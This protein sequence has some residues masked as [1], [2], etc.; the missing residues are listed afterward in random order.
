M[1]QNDGP[2]HVGA[3]GVH[4]FFIISGFVMVITSRH[5]K[6]SMPA[7]TFLW[8]RFLRIY[9]TYWLVAS[10]YLVLHL[11]IWRR[12]PLTLME[13]AASFALYSEY[14]SSIIG[15]GWTL[16]Y[17]VY[18]Y[19]CFALSLL[20]RR[21][22]VL[23]TAFFVFSVGAAPVIGWA[24]HIA[25][26]S[27]LI[28]FVAGC[29]LGCFYLRRPSMLG[30]LG[31]PSLILGIVLLFSTIILPRE[32]PSGI[33]MGLPSMLIVAGAVSMENWLQGRT[34]RYIA[35]LGESSY[36]LYLSHVLLLEVFVLTISNNG[37][38]IAVLSLLFAIACL[39]V[40][41]VGHFLVE[42]PML[43]ALAR[44]SLRSAATVNQFKPSQTP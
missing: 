41:H 39:I 24:A 6:D 22:I 29:W 4:I 25:T 31:L 43:R 40:A 3:S 36:F 37:A 19:L 35:Q 2:W 38:S 9:P 5:G 32:L 14:A 21:G 17:E 44:H 33:T 8:R 15:Q 34:A 7:T 28:E 12:N 1:A 16:A 13:Y 10:A 23:L 42:A 30:R 20:F 11:V 27:I 18:F 26:N